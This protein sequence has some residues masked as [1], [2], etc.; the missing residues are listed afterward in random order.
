MLIL[1]GLIENQKTNFYKNAIFISQLYKYLYEKDHLS[2]FGNI[3]NFKQDDC[4]QSIKDLYSLELRSENPD[5]DSRTIVNR[6]YNNKAELLQPKY[7]VSS[8]KFISN[9]IIDHLINYFIET[10]IIKNVESSY[11]TYSEEYKSIEGMNMD[12]LLSKFNIEDFSRE[13]GMK[14]GKYFRK[15]KNYKVSRE[16]IEFEQFEQDYK[17]L[18][19]DK[20]QLIKKYL[21]D[22]ENFGKN[23]AINLIELIFWMDHNWWGIRNHKQATLLSEYTDELVMHMFLRK[24]KVLELYDEGETLYATN[25]SFYLFIIMLQSIMR[26]SYFTTTKKSN[27]L[28]EDFSRGKRRNSEIVLNEKLERDRESFERLSKYILN[29]SVDHFRIKNAVDKAKN[30]I[31]SG[32]IKVVDEMLGNLSEKTYDTIESYASVYDSVY[33]GW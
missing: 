28:N 9:Y 24:K 6:L 21:M 18:A 20:S 19:N 8:V 13:F 22:S 30:E 26:M 1:E 10:Q 25:E 32:D 16:N 7:K 2:Y 11:Y 14:I 31:L 5:D 17:E 23:D 27:I 33:P 3:K 29:E 15:V 4:I 12:E